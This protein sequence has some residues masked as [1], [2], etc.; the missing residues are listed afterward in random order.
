[1]FL[2]SQ[3]GNLLPHGG[4]GQLFPPG[5]EHPYLPADL[6]LEWTHNDW[7]AASFRLNVTSAVFPGG[8]IFP[9]VNVASRPPEPNTVGIK[10]QIS[11]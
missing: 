10:S 7:T 3:R 4:Q 9:L 6:L 11:L 2:H 1:M 8:N 5:S